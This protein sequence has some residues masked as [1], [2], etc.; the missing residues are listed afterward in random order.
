MTAFSHF[1]RECLAVGQLLT[2]MIRMGGA[3]H[4]DI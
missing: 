1:E 3:S 2:A 4:L